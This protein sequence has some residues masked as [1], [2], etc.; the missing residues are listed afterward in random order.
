[1]HCSGTIFKYIVSLNYIEDIVV[2]HPA[3][4]FLSPLEV[5]YD[6]D[7]DVPPLDAPRLLADVIYRATMSSTMCCENA[8]SSI[9]CCETTTSKQLGWLVNWDYHCLRNQ[10]LC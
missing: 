3:P 1:M 5:S 4:R 10:F 6:S 9:T 8:T 2:P 7:A